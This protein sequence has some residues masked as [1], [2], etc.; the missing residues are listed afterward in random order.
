MKRFTSIL[1]LIILAG[2]ASSVPAS[3]DGWAYIGNDPDGTQN[4]LM[5]AATP[6]PQ[7][8]NLTTTFRY[9]YTAPRSVTDDKGKSIVYVERRDEVRVNCSDQSLQVLDR[10]YYDVEDKQ[11]LNQPTAPINAG[12]ERVIPGGINDIMYQAVCGR[13]IGWADIGTSDDSSQKI[14]IMGKAATQPVNGNVQAW[15]RTEYAGVQTL[16][17]AP[18]MR[19]I[20]YATKISTLK[21]DC[22][23]FKVGLLHEV[24]YDSDNHKVFDIQPAGTE[25]ES[26]PATAGSVRGLM[27]RAACGR[28]T[29]L[30]YLGMD[31]H[32]TQKVYVIGKPALDS[33][34]MARAQFRIYYLKP[35]TLTTGPVIHTV[36]YSERYVE[37]DADCSALTFQVHRETYLDNHGD[38]VFTIMPPETD[39]PN[40]GVAPGSLSEMLWKTACHGAG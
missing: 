29:E 23:S 4:I 40:V 19:R 30:H 36:S 25:A 21:F 11:V 17:A 13:S 20:S 12:S 37:L 24:Y 18:S 38:P 5:S 7:N 9:Q 1:W 35:G 39:T 14:G 6:V 2:C 8:G 10:R 15:F 26:L 31:P 28:P 33:N 3:R 32:H 34:D 16:I 27:Y 22:T